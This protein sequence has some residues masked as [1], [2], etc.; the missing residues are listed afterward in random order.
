MSN[1]QI[2]VQ[3][4]S[5]S[6]ETPFEH[7]AFDAFEPSGQAF[8]TSRCLSGSDDFWADAEYH[9]PGYITIDG[10]RLNAVRVY[11]FELSDMVSDDAGGRLSEEDYPWDAKHCARILIRD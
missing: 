7:V 11:L 5:S 3:Y 4:T 9:E 8:C 2:D 1:N 10:D 6:V